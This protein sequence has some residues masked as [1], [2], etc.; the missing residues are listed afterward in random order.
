MCFLVY[1]QVAQLSHESVIGK[2]HLMIDIKSGHVQ[3]YSQTRY[4][5]L[6]RLIP[7]LWGNMHEAEV[8]TENEQGIAIPEFQLGRPSNG[9]DPPR[10]CI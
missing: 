7:C 1:N 2:E 4:P 5:N 8:R 9:R 6:V 10:N 3:F